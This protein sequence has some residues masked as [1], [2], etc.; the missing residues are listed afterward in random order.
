M[1]TR[2]PRPLTATVLFLLIP[3]IASSNPARWDDEEP[4]AAEM[5]VEE[6]SDTELLGQVLMLGY[7]G[8][9]ATPEILAW[10]RDKRI[11]GI[12][13]FGWNV[14][15]LPGLARS[16]SRMQR[17]AV[18]TPKGIPLLIATDQEGGWVRHIKEETSITAGNLAIGATR[19]PRDAYFSGY[20]IGMELR[21][22]GVN[23][24]FAPTVDVYSNPEAHVIG[25]RAFSSDPLETARLAVAYYR[26][27]DAT[28]V[29]ATAKHFPGHGRADVD[30]HGALPLIDASFEELW[31]NDLL[32]YRFLVREE[33][34]AIMVGHLGFPGITGK[35]EPAT[36]SRFF[37]TEVLRNR[38]GFEGV[39]ITDD[40]RMSGV[41][42]T[43]APLDEIALRA[44]EAGNDILMISRTP[45]EH[46]TVW[47]RLHRE[48]GSNPAFRAK[49]AAAAERILRIKL[50]YLKNPDGVPLYPDPGK[51]RE[52]I[53]DPEA[54][55]FFFDLACRSVSLVKDGPLPLR[56]GRLGRVLL[57]GQYRRFLN[58]GTTRF[59]EADTYYFSYD[60]FY[61]AVP[62]EKERFARLAKNYDTVIFCLANPNSL[63]VLETLAKSDVRVI[64]FSVLS[65]VYLEELDWTDASIAVYG[66]GE[67]SF[68]AGFAVLAGDYEPE[69]TLP[70]YL[71]GRR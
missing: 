46:E 30:S 65:P 4:V 36:L 52:G 39:C 14:E 26:G 43:G 16:I 59:P 29:I 37:Q 12:K 9:E 27:L 51:V 24:N 22:L 68:A 10:I 42:D 67:E 64:T 20:Y 34:P 58:A 32:P 8:T 47:E 13:I 17:E 53:P 6:M 57:A 45:E 19:L 56:S 21:T 11:G 7:D 50:R 31:E 60:P 5:L 38:L 71:Q 55:R 3:V 1:H 2:K 33:L 23:M 49:V 61:T 15:S 66:V 25:P 70:L 54:K 18:R 48:M 62:S 35:D 63:E 41:T 40:L 69:G 28:G 44:L